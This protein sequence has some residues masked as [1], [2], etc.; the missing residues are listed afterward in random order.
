LNNATEPIVV[1]GRDGRIVMANAAAAQLAGGAILK[2]TFEESFALNLNGRLAKILDAALAGETVRNVE[3][4]AHVQGEKKILLISA[5]PLGQ[6]PEE[7]TGCVI[8]MTDLTER[9]ETLSRLKDL[10]ETLERRVDERTEQLVHANKELEGFCYSVSHDLRAPLRSMMSAAMILIED[11]GAELERDAKEQ[12]TKLSRNAKR[13][14]DLIDDLLHFSR[15]GRKQMLD[16]PIDLSAIAQSVVEEFRRSP[17][18]EHVRFDVQTGL[19]CRGDAILLHL[20]LEN[21][22]GNAIKFTKEKPEAHIEIGR[23]ETEKGPAFFVRDNGIGFDQRY[24]HKIFQPF[25]RLHSESEYPGTG[26]GLANVQRILAR[27]G[28]EV[29][30]E[31]V[32][33]E[34]AT[35]FFTLPGPG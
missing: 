23:E 8:T 1:C 7:T 29:W 9:K 18:I 2:Q 24:V 27:H 35:F 33:G 15:L 17:E 16:K 25:E 12:L 28:G 4:E 13:M 6:P 22:L 31:A 32:E 14:G 26:I 3:A 11:H 20:A 5:G 19:A 34:G 10:N 21:L 30:A